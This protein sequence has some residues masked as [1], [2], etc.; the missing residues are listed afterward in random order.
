[1]PVTGYEEVKP[2]GIMPEDRM[3]RWNKLFR[4]YGIPDETPG[5]MEKDREKDSALDKLK[6]DA[7]RQFLPTAPERKSRKKK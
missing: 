1:M 3:R 7:V 5:T 2:M 4:R 6:D